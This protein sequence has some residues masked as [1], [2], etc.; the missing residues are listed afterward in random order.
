VISV[1]PRDQ[2]RGDDV[3][4]GH[5]ISRIPGARISRARRFM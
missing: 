4:L 3:T 2:F 5:D 1:D